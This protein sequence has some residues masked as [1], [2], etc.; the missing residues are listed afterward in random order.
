MKVITIIKKGKGGP[1][2]VEP[3]PVVVPVPH[4]DTRPV[5]EP[6][7]P[8]EPKPK[9][10]FVLD[11]EAPRAPPHDM[12]C[13]ILGAKFSN[14]RIRGELKAISYKCPDCHFAKNLYY[15]DSSIDRE[16]AATRLLRWARDCPGDRDVHKGRGGPLCVQYA[17]DPAGSAAAASGS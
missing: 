7:E 15:V 10:R 3:P 16:E 8:V 14:V 2:V 4:V 12:D 9:K 11:P 5:A 6:E 17:E 1:P 13:W